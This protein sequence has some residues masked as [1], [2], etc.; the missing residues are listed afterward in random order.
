M[1]TGRIVPDSSA[2]IEFLRGTGSAVDAE[3]DALLADADRVVVTGPV[4]LE[5][6]AG[7]RTWDVRTRLA[8]LLARFPYARVNDPEDFE[9]AAAVY[10]TCRAAGNTFRGHVDCVIAVIA[11]RLGAAVLHADGDFDVIAQHAPLKLA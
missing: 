10:R 4:T 2:W 5:L 1:S 3:L 9:D 11:M 7:A 8:N 6:L